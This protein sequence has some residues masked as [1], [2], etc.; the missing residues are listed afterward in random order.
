MPNWFH[1]VKQLHYF[2]L[3]QA[4]YP[5]LLSTFLTG[6]VFIFRASLISAWDYRFLPWNLFLAWIPYLISLVTVYLHH[7]HPKRWGYLLMSGL[8]WLVFFPNAP[9]IV[10]DF[11]HLRW[12]HPVP[13]WYDIVLLAM[14]AWTG[15]FL[16]AF[17][18]RTMQQIVKKFLG[19]IISWF[20]VALVMGLSGLGIYLGRFFRWNS[21][22]LLV[23][24][25]KIL[26]DVVWLFMAPSENVVAFG[27]ILQIS[28][29]LLVCY[30]T[31]MP[32]SPKRF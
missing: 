23:Q 30:L 32:V 15:L 1:R 27:F 25:D 17:S 11:I 20:F 21:W 29:L 6:W 10:T 19:I 31:L 4:L 22:D 24:P 8:V 12:R 9:Y 26:S 3:D 7:H 28:A 18:L 14:A 5:V 13:I 2:L 16:A